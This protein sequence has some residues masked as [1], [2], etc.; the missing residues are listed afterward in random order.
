MCDAYDFAIG[1]V[2]GQYNASY[3]LLSSRTST[4][5]RINCSTTEKELL[6]VVLALDKFCLYLMCSKVIVFTDRVPLKHLLPKMTP[7]MYS[8]GEFCYPSI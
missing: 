4:T 1:V 7:N 5:A 8:L 3:H 6:V 2:L